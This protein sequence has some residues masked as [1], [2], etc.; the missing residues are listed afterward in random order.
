[1]R[2][3]RSLEISSCGIFIACGLIGQNHGAGLSRKQAFLRARELAAVGRKMFFDPA[4]SASGKLSCA[5]CHDP[6]FAYG[7]P[8]D[9]AVQRGG[10]DME[11]WGIRAV[12]SL[13]YLQAIPQFTVH[14]FDSDATGVDSID[15]GPTGGLAWDGRVDRGRDQARIPLLSPL[16]MANDSAENVVAKVLKRSYASEIRRLSRARAN[17]T[18]LFNTILE[19]FEAWEQDSAE[20]YPYSSKYDAWLA[21]GVKLTDS[22]ERGRKLFSD[23]NK[24]D[25]ARCHIATRGADGTP[26]QFTD[27]GLIALGVPRNNRIPANSNQSWHD[28]G[29][30]GP[31]R[32]DLRTREEY[33]GRFRTPSLRNVALR[34][35]FFHNG[36][37]QTLREAIEFYAQR[38]TNP[39]KWYP[40]SID[41]NVLKYDDLPSKY[42]GNVEAGTPFGGSHGAAPALTNDE[43]EDVVAFLGTLTDGF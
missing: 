40:K 26:P 25:C 24:G 27:Y 37:F 11:Q 21:G 18:D 16:E 28:L 23:S 9:M 13:K 8:N 12:P 14:Y 34:K 2:L 29:M 43:I 17:S 1:V 33:C 10:K 7:P 30:C 6:S 39:E 4:L 22:E 5:S 41:G 36:V 31:E 20:F 32:I 38:D 35:T 19:A 42:H 15:N 3:S